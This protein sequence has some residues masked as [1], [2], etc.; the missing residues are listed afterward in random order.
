MR[1]KLEQLFFSVEVFFTLMVR[2][3]KWM[4]GKRV[5]EMEFKIIMDF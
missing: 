5:E 2:T 3:K 1:R 4:I